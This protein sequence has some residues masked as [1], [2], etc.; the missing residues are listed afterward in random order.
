MEAYHSCNAVDKFRG[1]ICICGEDLG[2]IGDHRDPNGRTWPQEK[3]RTDNTVS[4]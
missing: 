3:F 1:K 4:L 2:H